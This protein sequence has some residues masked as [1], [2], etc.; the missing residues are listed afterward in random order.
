MPPHAYVATMSGTDVVCAV[1]G[2]G[3]AYMTDDHIAYLRDEYGADAVECPGC[4]DIFA[5]EETVRMYEF[6]GIQAGPH[7]KL[8]VC[9]SC[10]GMPTPDNV[11]QTLASKLA[12]G[13]I[14]PEEYLR[15]LDALDSVAKANSA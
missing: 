2:C 11:Y 7:G 3:R 6:R 15:R 5:L 10:A 8:R 4:K 1:A 13:Y 9:H 14:T 12:R